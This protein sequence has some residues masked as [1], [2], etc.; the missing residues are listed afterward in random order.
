MTRITLVSVRP[1][2]L[3]AREGTKNAGQQIGGFSYIGFLSDGKPLEFTSRIGTHPVHV[4]QIGFDPNMCV[5]LVI[6][7]KLFEGKVKYSE[8]LPEAEGEPQ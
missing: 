1:W 3:T 8:L 2:T 6:N 7:T 5:E 4:G